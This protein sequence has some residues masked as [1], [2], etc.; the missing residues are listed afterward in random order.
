[1]LRFGKL[2]GKADAETP[3]ISNTCRMNPLVI[4]F[5]EVIFYDDFTKGKTS[6]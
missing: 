3:C 1:M 2:A 4:L 5:E 6:F